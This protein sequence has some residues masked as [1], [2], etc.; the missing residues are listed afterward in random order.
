MEHGGGE[1]WRRRKRRGGVAH[2]PSS[3]IPP[4]SELK[5]YLPRRARYL[6]A[7]LPIAILGKCYLGYLGT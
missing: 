6:A 2:L 5:D 1:G 7:Y 4:S 3:S